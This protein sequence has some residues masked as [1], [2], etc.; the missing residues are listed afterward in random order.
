MRLASL[1]RLL[2]CAVFLRQLLR[3]LLVLLLHLLRTRVAG[4]LLGKLL[5]FLIL[6]LLKRLA[7]LSLLGDQ[8]VL[9]LFVLLVHLR[10]PRVDRCRASYRWKFLGMDCG[11]GLRSRTAAS[12]PG[13]LRCLFGAH[14]SM[15][16][17]FKSPGLAV[18]AIAGVP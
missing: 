8:L 5:M 11:A 14:R 15:F 3:L 2:L 9:I 7:F 6:L 16:P 4:L 13:R 10:I 17:T 1:Q 18:A 12:G